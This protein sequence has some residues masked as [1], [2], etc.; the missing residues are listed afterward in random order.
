MPTV[1]PG[2]EPDAQL[3]W[4]R[5]A[6]AMSEQPTEILDPLWQ[7]TDGSVLL[8][9]MPVLEASRKRS[10]SSKS[11]SRTQTTRKLHKGLQAQTSFG[12][13]MLV[14]EIYKFDRKKRETRAPTRDTRGTSLLE[15]GIRIRERTYDHERNNRDTESPDT[16]TRT[17]HVQHD[18][19]PSPA[20]AEMGFPIVHSPAGQ[21]GQESIWKR[22]GGPVEKP[23]PT[24]VDIP[25]VR[26]P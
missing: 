19:E 13:D 8:N 10:R 26:P 24:N 15:E 2:T 20:F 25:Q 1:Q 16:A 5:S 6:D 22:A 11:T 18:G 23:F 9:Q 21:R 12:S 4:R 14:E 7:V 3:V 17:L